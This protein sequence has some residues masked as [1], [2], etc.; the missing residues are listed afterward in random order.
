MEDVFPPLAKILDV[1]SQTERML[2]KQEIIPV[3][4]QTIQVVQRGPKPTTV[5][6]GQ[7]KF[8]DGDAKPPPPAPLALT[9]TQVSVQA[10]LQM[11][12]RLVVLLLE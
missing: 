4:L 2:V 8:V 12:D 10:A 6:V 9:A 1:V 11:R 7:E 5:P 3:I